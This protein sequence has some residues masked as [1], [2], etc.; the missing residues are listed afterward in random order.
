MNGAAKA[1]LI[2][3]LL[4][5]ALAK[6]QSSGTFTATGNMTMPRAGHIATLLFNGKVLIAVV[7]PV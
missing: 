3:L 6:A 4:S 1:N 7:S 5:S 2:V